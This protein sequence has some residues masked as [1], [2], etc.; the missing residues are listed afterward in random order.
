MIVH[1]KTREE[2]LENRRK[3]IGGSDAP[4]ICGISQWN[5]RLGVWA[6]KRGVTEP[7]KE[8]EWHK[9]GL[10]LERS[11]GDLVAWK[12]DRELIVPPKHMIVRSEDPATRFMGTTID[13]GIMDGEKGLGI[14][15]IKNVGGRN[16]WMWD[17]EPPAAVMVQNQHELR[18]CVTS[19]EFTRE[20]GEPKYGMIGALLGGNEIV[21]YDQAPNEKFTGWLVNEERKLWDMIES[22]EQPEPEGTKSCAEVLRALYTKKPG[23]TIELGDE[24]ADVAAA[25]DL[26]KAKYQS[27]ERELDIA[28]QKIVV[29]IGE[30]KRAILPDGTG[31]SN[32][33]IPGGFVQAKSYKKKAHR[34]L[35]RIGVKKASKS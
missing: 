32:P 26:A 30:N 15:Q 13:F 33:L 29:A 17:D 5:T 20:Y 19:K 25:Y 12:S 11:I 24:M 34:R 16:A 10:T 3:T 7:G 4:A 14:L 23:G 2:W 35:T 28:K 27:W 8:E 21:W 22:G 18:T 6:D 1:S 9:I 31:F